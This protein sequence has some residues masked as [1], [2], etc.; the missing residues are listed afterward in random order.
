MIQICIAL[1]IVGVIFLLLEMLWP[2]MEFFAIF[3]IVVL[4]ISIVLAVLFV[5]NGWVIAAG[6]GI[7]II[8]FVVHMYR[9]FKRKQLHG[10][11]ILDENLELHATE[12]MSYL[13]GRE[14]KTVTA[15]RPYGEADFNGVRVEV[16]S[17]GPAIDKGTK[18]CV[19]KTESDKITV[20][21]VRGAVN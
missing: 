21:P 10:K 20:Y 14:G 3:G 9:L 2:G 12:D 15:L 11:L 13:V 17:Y 19:T 8:G 5:P 4:S 18:I 16:S 6:Q 7:V 1:L